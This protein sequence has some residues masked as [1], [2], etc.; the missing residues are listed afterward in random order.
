MT[1]HLG[2]ETKGAVQRAVDVQVALSS[3]AVM[4]CLWLRA[5]GCYKDDS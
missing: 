1:G 4:A 3:E 5:D 2:S